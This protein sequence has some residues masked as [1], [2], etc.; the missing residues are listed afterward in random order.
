[1]YETLLYEVNEGVAVITLNRPEAN[2]AFSVDALRETARV[3]EHCSA[4]EN[5]RVAI[6]TGNGKHF[7]VGGDIKAMTTKGFISYEN[8]KLT[9]ALGIA[10][11]NCAK[12][13]VAAI[14]GTAAGA[15]LGLALGWTF[16]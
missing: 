16:G 13:V 4:D 9:T 15:G 14:N 8:A 12:P 11:K 5:A 2:N 10:P 1:M 6:V 7:S 3:F